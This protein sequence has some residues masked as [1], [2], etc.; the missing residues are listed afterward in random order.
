MAAIDSNRTSGTNWLSR[1]PYWKGMCN[2][3]NW[4]KFVRIPL[5]QRDLYVAGRDRRPEFY[6]WSDEARRKLKVIGT[7]RANRLIE[8]L[9]V[10]YQRMLEPTTEDRNE[11]ERIVAA[12]CSDIRR[13]K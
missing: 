5:F 8:I 12:V 2:D 6:G 4:W 11:H 3:I 9:C 10:N 1:L 7:Q 13:A